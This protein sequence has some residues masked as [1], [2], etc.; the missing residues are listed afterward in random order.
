MS[1]YITDNSYIS[2]ALFKTSVEVDI[3]LLV[4]ILLLVQINLAP[5]YVRLLYY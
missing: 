5:F 3:F 1:N 2:S 4:N